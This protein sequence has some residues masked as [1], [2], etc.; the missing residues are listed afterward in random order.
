MILPVCALT[1]DVTIL[2]EAA[3]TTDSESRRVEV[4]LAS[5]VGATPPLQPTPN[6]RAVAEARHVVGPSWE[7]AR[8]GASPGALRFGSA[9]SSSL[10]LAFWHFSTSHLPA[11]AVVLA[12]KL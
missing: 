3:S 4:E 5:T 9:A 8:E 12:V 1:F 7:L 11:S 10:A 6:S 2:S